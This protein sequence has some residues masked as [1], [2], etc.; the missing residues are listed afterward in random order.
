MER[1]SLYPG[2][3]IAL[4]VFTLGSVGGAHL[5]AGQDDFTGMALFSFLLRCGVIGVAVNFWMYRRESRPAARGRAASEI[6]R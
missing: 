1:A 2:S 3:A 5:A 6:T 4:C